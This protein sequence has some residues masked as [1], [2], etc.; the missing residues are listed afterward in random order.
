MRR[1]RITA[2]LLALGMIA[3]LFP[4]CGETKE[5]GEKDKIPVLFSIPEGSGEKLSVTGKAVYTDGEELSVL[6]REE[7]GKLRLVRYGAECFLDGDLQPTVWEPKPEEERPRAVYGEYALYT[8]RLTV[9]EKEIPLDPAPQD[10]YAGFWSFDGVDY[11]VSDRI[12][13][14]MA[15]M[16]KETD[17][18]IVLYPVTEEGLGDPVRIEGTYIAGFSTGTDGKWNYFMKESVLYRTDGKTLQNLGNPTPFGVNLSKLRSIVPLDEERVLLL[19]GKNLIL[20]ALGEEGPTGEPTG[21]EGFGNLVI[22]MDVNISSSF[23]ELVAR[24]NMA[25][26]Y[27]VELKEYVDPEKLNLALLNQEVDIV[28]TH[29][30]DLIKNYAEK[31]LLTPLDGVIGDLV[32]S[33]D[34]FPNVLQMGKVAG[35]L[36]MI[37]NAC[38]V[39]GM[40]LP[41][42]VVEEKGG[43]FADMKDLLET[44]D[45]LEDRRF[46]NSN[47]RDITLGH[48]SING[49]YRAWV[50]EEAG[51]CS[52]EDESFIALLK[53][54]SRYAPDS[55][56]VAANQ[57]GKRP[58][59]QTL[60]QMYTPG[61]YEWGLAYENPKGSGK[62]DSPYGLAGQ[63]FPCPTGKN[64]GYALEP[65]LLFGVTETCT[66][67]N[68]AGE[69]LSWILSEENQH[70]EDEVLRIQMQDG[71]M[72]VRISSFRKWMEES[73]EE[74]IEKGYEVFLSADHYAS[75]SGSSEIGKVFMEEGLRYL[76]GEITAEKAAEYIQN[77]V[78]IYLAEQG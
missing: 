11:L 35:E 45:G 58:L 14:D 55:A 39:L 62:T 59:F 4:A 61:G 3:G 34:I 20:L 75:G 69:F 7:N 74:N 41:K 37:P 52:F 68:S 13:F 8:D 33:G 30:A 64:T 31:K 77:R 70:P 73:K 10:N 16:E 46:F 38:M 27:K 25:S 65:E 21:G 42:T 22:G 57:N 17:R 63:I 54:C 36:Y 5:T 26:D 49:A 23:S 44:L 66:V 28:A 71:G 50:D 32:S 29:D 19:S 6:S 56:T 1:R 78:S 12:V 53:F 47:T 60:Y 48:F 24:Y 18:Y 51:T 76:H 2:F 67:K 9:G 43:S 72:P 15:D 40:M